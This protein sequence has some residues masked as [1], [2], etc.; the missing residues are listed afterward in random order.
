MP[1]AAWQGVVALIL[2]LQLI[3]VVFLWTL[4][5]YDPQAEPAFALY[6]VVVLL[7]FTMI[8][9]AYRGLKQSN[10]VQKVPILAGCI[11]VISLLFVGL[12]I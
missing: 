8:S 3:S 4:N 1:E 7:S 6:L 10:T 5:P 9:Y 11:V 12:F 2:V